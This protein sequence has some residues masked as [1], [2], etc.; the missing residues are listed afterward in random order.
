MTTWSASGST[1]PTPAL[2]ITGFTVTHPPVTTE[3]LRWPDG[4]RGPA[5]PSSDVEKADLS[6]YAE[7][8]I[9]VG[10]QAIAAAGGTQDVYHLEQLV[11]DVGTRTSEAAAQATRTTNQVVDDASKVVRDASTQATNALTLATE[12]A[13]LSFGQSVCNA[14]VQLQE[15]VLHLFGGDDPQVVAR[16]DGL[17][18]RFES[19]LV[20]RTDAQTT[21]LFNA[22]VK[23]LN[24]DDPGS[25]LA[26]HQVQIQR[27]HA[28]LTE[29]L[30]KQNAQVV[31]R[32]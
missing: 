6:A 17:L 22:A 14:K 11:Q 24:P 12:T 18:A 4:R 29:R 21:S 2:V 32:L 1:R 13:R 31:E 19:S 20:Q 10:A 7:Q 15:Q 28:D 27:Q 26:R 16:L 23:A 30:E 8:A 25:P 3:A 5:Q 9:V